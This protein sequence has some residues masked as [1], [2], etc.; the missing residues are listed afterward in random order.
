VIRERRSRWHERSDRCRRSGGTRAVPDAL[1]SPRYA[2]C[3]CG[4]RPDL[5]THYCVAAAPHFRR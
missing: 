3:A 4:R 1:P 2:L 5:G